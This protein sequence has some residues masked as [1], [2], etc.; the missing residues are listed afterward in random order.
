MEILSREIERYPRESSPPKTTP[1]LSGAAR[2][3]GA[4]RRR[5]THPNRK[6]PLL[7]PWPHISRAAPAP[8]ELPRDAAARCRGRLLRRGAFRP[9]PL[10]P[11]ACGREPSGRSQRPQPSATRHGAA[12]RPRRS[13]A[14]GG[15]AQRLAMSWRAATDPTALAPRHT[16]GTCSGP[17]LHR[18]ITMRSTRRG[19]AHPRSPTGRPTHSARIGSQGA[20]TNI[21]GRIRV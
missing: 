5:S 3:P 12:R 6:R 19:K 7:G 1:N 4:P 21:G 15:G 16:W 20:R 10:H 17:T 11:P 18:G 9:V 2:A 14:G 13:G 8:P